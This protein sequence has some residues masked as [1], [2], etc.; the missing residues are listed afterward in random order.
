MLLYGGAASANDVRETRKVIFDSSFSSSSPPHSSSPSQRPQ[1]K[2]ACVEKRQSPPSRFRLGPKRNG[3]R[4]WRRHTVPVVL[5]TGNARQVVSSSPSTSNASRRSPVRV[6]SGRRL[7]SH[8]RRTRTTSASP[9]YHIIPVPFTVVVSVPS[10]NAATIVR[11]SLRSPQ[12]FTETR[13]IVFCG[14]CHTPIMWVG[15]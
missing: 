12:P 1:S 2:L 7:V 8:P 15:T 11:S 3:A 13:T 14:E 10:R 4:D 9:V 5:S 6:L